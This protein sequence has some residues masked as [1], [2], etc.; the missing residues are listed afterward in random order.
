MVVIMSADQVDVAITSL[1]AEG[2]NA[3]TV[4]E[5]VERPTGAP[6]TIVI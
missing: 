1:K 5:V 2:L 3:W 6:Q 4:G